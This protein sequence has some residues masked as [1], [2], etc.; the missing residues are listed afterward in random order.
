MNRG[1]HVRAGQVIAEL[2]SGDLA[3]AAEES[4]VSVR[5]SAGRLCHGDRRDRGR[6]R[7]QGASRRAVRAKRFDAAK[8]LYDNRVA[9]QKEGALA[10]K[11]VDDDQGCKWSRRKASSIP[12]SGTC[13]SLNGVSQREAIEGAQ[14]QMNA[15]KAH[16]DTLG[17]QLSYAQILSPINGVVADRPV[18]P[19]EMAAT[20]TP[21]I[22]IVDISQIRGASRMFR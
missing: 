11:L 2:E 19:G 15:A 3:A 8:K 20:G 6:R 18:Y 13:K 9:L 21:L 17:V 5:T 1:D 12:R 16:D 22:S 7:D 4:Q 10:Q 14:A